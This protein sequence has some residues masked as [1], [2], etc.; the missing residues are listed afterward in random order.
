MTSI[1]VPGSSD[2]FV[3]LRRSSRARRLS[4]RVSRTDGK[5]SLSLPL[6]L[7]VREAEKFVAEK[8]DWIRKHVSASPKAKPLVFGETIPF[9]GQKLTIEQG[10]VKRVKVH[11]GRLIC[12][13]S[14]DMLGPRIAA[15]LKLNARQ[16]LTAASGKYAKALGK[17]FNR[18][19]IR[20]TKS[21][22]GSC[23]SAGNLNYSWRLMMAPED[24]LDYVA[25]HEVAHLAL[26]DHS[27]AF[28]NVVEELMPDYRDKKN[29]LKVYGAEL[30]S[31][32]FD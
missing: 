1:P 16:A 25:A 17:P 21:R 24:V 31:I 26:M 19:T 9:C 2:I 3:T 4:L 5:V 27:P 7:P 30:Q 22:W 18:I 23:S 15:F 14:Q 20:D 32:R 10:S 28:W 13:P 29:W 6:R 12:P 8:A 11:R